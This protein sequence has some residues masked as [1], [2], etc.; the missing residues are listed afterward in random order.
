VVGRG[1]EAVDTLGGHDLAETVAFDEQVELGG[2]LADIVDDGA[3][4]GG[5]A[6]DNDLGEGLLQVLQH[7]RHV[8]PGQFRLDLFASLFVLDLCLLLWR[9]D[10]DP[11]GRRR[12]H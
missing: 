10:L 8:D 11:A 9:E 3:V 12:A 2:V 1:L 5:N 4:D 7:G 6:L